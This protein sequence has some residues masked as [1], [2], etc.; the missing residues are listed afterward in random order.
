MLPFGLVGRLRRETPAAHDPQMTLH[1]QLGARGGHLA[2]GVRLRHATTHDA[3]RA[4]RAR[5]GETE[6]ELSDFVAT[7]AEARAVVTL[8][9]ERADAQQ[10][11]ESRNWLERGG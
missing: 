8:H 5:G 6:L 10:L 3:I 4:G 1:A 2:R 7:D 9:E 11:T